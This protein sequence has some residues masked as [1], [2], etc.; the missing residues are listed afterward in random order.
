MENYRHGRL[1]HMFQPPGFAAPLQGFSLFSSLVFHG[2][3]VTSIS[4]YYAA[5][6]RSGPEAP[7]PVRKQAS[8]KGRSVSL[9][10]CMFLTNCCECVYVY[11][12]IYIYVYI[13]IYI[14]RGARTGPE[15]GVGNGPVRATWYF[16]M[17]LTNCCEYIY[18]YINIYIHI[19]IHICIY[20]IYI[21]IYIYIYM[22]RKM[23][24]C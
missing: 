14:S 8:G 19:Y 21:N 1:Y 13:Y 2:F 9:G 4:S 24:R 3:L 23:Y 10:I 12:Y 16:F 7:G 20:Y 18:I 6:V 15:T 17:C 22:Y 11:I 5:T